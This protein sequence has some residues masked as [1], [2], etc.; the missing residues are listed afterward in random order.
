MKKGPKQMAP[1][2]VRVKM[3]QTALREEE[4]RELVHNI[5]TLMDYAFVVA[6]ADEYGFGADR[7]RRVELR[8]DAILNEF[9]GLEKGTDIEYASEVLERRYRQ[10]IPEGVEENEQEEPPKGHNGGDGTDRL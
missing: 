4:R 5:V 8:V 6:L 7:A 9:L 3:A 1:Y 2:A 10:I